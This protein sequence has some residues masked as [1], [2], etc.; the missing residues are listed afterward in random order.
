[1]NTI[2]KVDDR[3]PEEVKR[4]KARIEHELIECEE[5]HEEFEI[6]ELHPLLNI[7]GTKEYEHLCE[8]CEEM[9]KSEDEPVATVIYGDDE[10]ELKY[11]RSYSDDTEGDFKATYHRTDGWRGYYDIT[12][13]N[14]S[15]IHSD[16]ILAYSSDS[17]EL[18]KFDTEFRRTLNNMGIRYARV[19]SRTSNL[20][21]SG[22]DFFVEKGK[23]MVA[24]AIRVVLAL[25]YRDPERFRATA[26]TGANPEDFDEHD[27]LFVKAVKLLDEGMDPEDAVKA[28]M[29]EVEE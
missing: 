8:K 7:D 13:E 14:W 3:S 1:M 4:N 26:L 28:V 29:A 2:K 12:S 17:A 24:N 22:Y 16:C 27:K 6:D 5:C 15:A 19:T 10:E 18:E 25:K 11:I 9:F 20:F 23:E 21:S